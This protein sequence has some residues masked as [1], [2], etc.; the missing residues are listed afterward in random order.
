MKVL[1][2]CSG[3]ICRSPLIA[4][5]LKHRARAEGLSTLLVESRGLLGIEGERADPHAR[6]VARENGFDLDGHR[7]AGLRPSDVRSADLVLA[8]T[9]DH[10]D[11]LRR[12]FPGDAPPILLIRAFEADALPRG[13]APDVPDP[14]GGPIEAFRESF[15]IVKPCVD[16]LVLHL[17]HLP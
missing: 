7:S 8:M 11:E 5:Y 1:V 15:R 4:G 12:R 14:I 13:G 2:V 9:L 10:V 17:K 16:H 6:Q 3:N